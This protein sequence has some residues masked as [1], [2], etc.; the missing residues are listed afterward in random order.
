MKK[1]V[2]VFFLC[3]LLGMLSGTNIPG[4]NVSGTWTTTGS[5]YYVQG[6]ITIP[7]G[8]SLIINPGVIVR[9]VS[10][11]S[12]TVLGTLSAEGTNANRIKM[13]AY[14][15]RNWAGVVFNTSNTC[16]L[17]YIE[18]STVIG[19]GA[20][21]INSSSNITIQHCK[22]NSN[23]YV[24]TSN[25]VEKGAGAISIVDSDSINVNNCVIYDN[26]LSTGSDNDNND[27]YGCS[28]ISM[29]N[30]NECEIMSN[31][32][33]DNTSPR[34]GT[35]EVIKTTNPARMTT[36]N[37]A[38]NIIRDN[39]ASRGGAILVENLTSAI[40]NVVTV[41]MKENQLIRNTANSCGGAIC[42]DVNVT[43]EKNTICFNQTPNDGGGIYIGS[44]FTF[45]NERI[46]GNT[47]YENDASHGAGIFCQFTSENWG[48]V[49][50]GDITQNS[51]Y[52]NDALVEGG[53]IYIR[54]STSV[55]SMLPFDYNIINNNHAQKGAGIYF[56]EF[57]FTDVSHNIIAYNEASISGSGFYEDSGYGNINMIN[58]I[59][60]GNSVNGN[61]TYQGYIGRG[62]NLPPLFIS[63]ISNCCIQNGS[64]GIFSNNACLFG[65]NYSTNPQF[66]DIYGYDFHTTSPFNNCII[67]GIGV[68]SIAGSA[69]FTNTLRTG[70]NWVSFPRL[71][72]D[73]ETD[74]SVN[75]VSTILANLSGTGSKFYDD[76]SDS[77]LYVN[78]AWTGSPALA[79]IKSSEGYKIKMTSAYSLTKTGTTI[80]PNTSL[81]LMPN[82]EN[83]V[84]YFMPVTLT[85]EEALGSAMDNL[86][87]IKTEDWAMSRPNTNSEWLAL[88]SIDKSM[89]ACFNYGDMV[90]LKIAGTD[91]INVQWLQGV[92]RQQQYNRAKTSTFT[93]MEQEDYTPIYV[94]IN[95]KDLPQE[96]GVMVNGKCVGA[97]IVEG[98][99]TEINAY[100]TPKDQGQKITLALSYDGIIVPMSE[101]DYT[102]MNYE[103]MR[104]EVKT[105][106][107]DHQDSYYHILVGKSSNPVVVPQISLNQ[108][109]PNPF[110]PETTIS[111]YVPKESKV[112]LTIYNIR[113]QKVKNLYNGVVKSGLQ[114]IVWD[115]RDNNNQKT[116]S[117]VYFYQ[118]K[119][120]N[121][122]VQ[123]K[124]ALIK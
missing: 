5:P 66:A 68:Y 56:K 74:A 123:K 77:L 100:L 107:Y 111:Y 58:T 2:L 90:S 63:T 121:Q 19:K 65:T 50:T 88:S 27:L 49:I 96:I 14:L 78:N 21:Q 64:A 115:G 79:T 29:Y 38:G 16:R 104:Q 103:S 47:I 35:V 122:V 119:V 7:V 113:G 67:Y 31:E 10:N 120:G 36:I 20:F 84:G 17:Y 22:F 34:N 76:L 62:Q 97:A 48:R 61:T 39:T 57:G 116:A 41:S 26:T 55:T 81:V 92:E 11:Y 24:C 46:I 60:W 6:N 52:N 86:I 75:T 9:F 112:S 118:L 82:Q 110:N 54:S 72:R 109:Y 101:T 124:M 13:Q 91:T 4:G 25:Y 42:A 87:Q 12:L 33:Y 73:A 105:I 70:W 71:N 37:I 93:Y 108:N 114:K 45:Y 44:L 98:D 28:A 15:T 30:C 99:V 32:I 3:L 53:G 94:S 85:P 1:C 89:V 23:T 59:L 95:S 102:V 18:I 69:S 8:S 40:Q 80:N 51:I 106:F 43:I 117:G 83:W